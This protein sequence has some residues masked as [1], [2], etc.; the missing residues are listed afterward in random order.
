VLSDGDLI[1]TEA[2]SRYSEGGRQLAVSEPVGMSHNHS[3]LKSCLFW[4]YVN[5]VSFRL[6]GNA[7]VRVAD[8]AECLLNA[9]TTRITHSGNPRFLS[10]KKQA[11]CYIV[12]VSAYVFSHPLSFESPSFLHLVYWVS[13]DPGGLLNCKRAAEKYH[14]KSMEIL[15]KSAPRVN[16]QERNSRIGNQFTNRNI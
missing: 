4:S 3:R 12:G 7:H 11:L 5:R 10:C 15:L 8:Q 16:L 6:G 9:T 14:Y 13:L 2:H 1:I